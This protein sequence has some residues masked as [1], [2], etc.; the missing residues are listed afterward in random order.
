[1]QV[2]RDGKVTVLDVL[3]NAYIGETVF[4]TELLLKW[5]IHIYFKSF[6]N[7]RIFVR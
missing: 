4:V 6:Q 2:F 7:K 5:R 3:S 1:M